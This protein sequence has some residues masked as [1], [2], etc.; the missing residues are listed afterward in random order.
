MTVAKVTGLRRKGL[1]RIHSWIGLNLGLL[2]FLICFSGTVAVFGPELNWVAE[3]SLRVSPPSGGAEA[4]APGQTVSWQALHD[5]VADAFP[6]ARILYL[7]APY[8][9]RFASV[10]VISQAPGGFQLVMVNPYSG[11]VQGLK[12][13]FNIRSFFRIFHKQLYIVPTIF[14]FHGTLIVGALAILLLL[15]VIVGLLSMKHWRRAFVTLRRDRS[16]RLFWS[17]LHRLTG[18]WA[19]VVTVI[20]TLTGIW[21]L[22]ENI[23]IDAGVLTEDRKPPHLS[24]ATL[25]ARPAVLLPMDLDRAAALA[26]AAYP[27]LTVTR[28]A[29]PAR[30]GAPL[31]FVGQAEAWLVRDRGNQIA[32]D[33]YTG[34]V[35]GIRRAI[36]LGAFDRWIDTA[37]P[38]HFGTFGGLGTRIVWFTAGLFLCGG[39]LS[40]L[41]GVWMR[42]N[43]RKNPVPKRRVLAAAAIAPTLVLVAASILGTWLYGGQALRLAQLPVSAVTV[44][45][46]DLGPWRIAINRYDIADEKSGPVRVGVTFEGE[47]HANFR[48]AALWHGDPDQAGQK[49]RLRRFNDRLLARVPCDRSAG[50]RT[51]K[52]TLRMDAWDGTQYTASVDIWPDRGSGPSA[53]PIATG[54]SVGE[55]I[56]MGVFVLCLLIPLLGWVRLQFRAG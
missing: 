53:L 8:G 3:P 39:I 41:Y 12:S 1:F 46:S 15:G 32:L 42:S 54:V 9:D 28:V 35:L 51:C 13:S 27:E 6:A 43:R 47:G 38:L 21:Y 30:P 52:L 11:A 5:S 49:L 10:A 18:V 25:R 48:D 37:D 34:D 14:R 17:D 16:P 20:L 33:P 23:L 7:S 36:D 44:M 19:L 55:G 2:L 50:G 56:V 24:A 4:G 22:A 26:K 31:V 40:G 29:L 45:R